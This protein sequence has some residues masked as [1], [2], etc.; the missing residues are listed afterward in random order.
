MKTDIHTFVHTGGRVRLDRF[1]TERLAGKASRAVVQ[2][3]IGQGCVQ[4]NGRAPKSVHQ[5][6]RTE[7]TVTVA[8][9]ETSHAG[10]AEHFTIADIRI[11]HETQE[12]V[13]VEKPAGMLTHTVKETDVGGRDVASLLLLAYPKM[14]GVGQAHR[15]GIVH[16]LDKKVSGVMVVARTQE[17]YDF[18]RSQFKER[19]VSKEYLALVHGRVAKDEGEIRFAISRSKKS[20]KFVAKP[21]LTADARA[22]YALT[23]FAVLRRFRGYTL[24]SLS[25][26]TGRTHQ[27]RAHLSAYGHPVVG[28]VM[29][30]PKTLKTNL[31]LDRLFLHSHKLGF[32]NVDSAWLEFL[33]PLP[34]ELSAILEKL[35][36]A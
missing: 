27:I 34:F 1:L 4:I 5:F 14:R 6:L 12:Y 9:G 26:H 20:G 23:H 35:P 2:K 8:Y 16:R 32:S 31:K 29:Y 19:R 10:S 33:S 28:D 7:D 11:I 15:C 3:W 22:K 17:M 21:A 30:C 25:I 18:L 13:V 24:L 36:A